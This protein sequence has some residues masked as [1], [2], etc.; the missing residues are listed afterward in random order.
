MGSG[1]QGEISG[2]RQLLEQHA[3][4]PAHGASG[5]GREFRGGRRGGGVLWAQDR[6]SGQE[7]VRQRGYHDHHS[8]GLRHCREFRHVLCGPERR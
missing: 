3:G 8:A 6:H 4:C 5:K 7:C 2:G 1:E